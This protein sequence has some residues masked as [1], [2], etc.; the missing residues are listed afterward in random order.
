M[1]RNLSKY[2]GRV[3]Q[4]LGFTSIRRFDAALARETVSRVPL[5]G[6]W[7]ARTVQ[8][9]NA[10]RNGFVRYLSTSPLSK[11][12]L[13]QET[14]DNLKIVENESSVALLVQGIVGNSLVKT[15]EHFRNNIEQYSLLQ[16]VVL[17]AC[18]YTIH[19]SLLCLDGVH[20]R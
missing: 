6:A 2:R 12:Q 9:R 8:L 11:E 5:T 1:L 19:V 3:V 7:S 13:D 14:S 20:P 15:S 10:G 18:E 4:G 16:Q 17:D